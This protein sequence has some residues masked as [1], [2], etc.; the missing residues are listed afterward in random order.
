MVLQTAYKELTDSLEVSYEGYGWNSKRLWLKTQ[1]NSVHFEPYC[2]SNYWSSPFW[3]LQSKVINF[4]EGKF[5]FAVELFFILHPTQNYSPWF[6]QML[7]KLFYFRLS[8]WVQNSEHLRFFLML[9]KCG[10]KNFG[11]P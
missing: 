11:R 1:K 9:N 3:M 6:N 10:K 2:F 8:G 4:C 5:R 7:K